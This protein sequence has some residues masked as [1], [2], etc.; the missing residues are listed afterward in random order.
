MTIPPLEP[1]K[2]YVEHLVEELMDDDRFIVA[3]A[4]RFEDDAFGPADFTEYAKAKAIEQ[5]EREWSE[6]MDFLLD[7][8]INN[9]E[10]H[11]ER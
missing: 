5:A 9:L 1:R 4:M 11:N 2:N 10:L 8:R 6:R 7:A 3:V